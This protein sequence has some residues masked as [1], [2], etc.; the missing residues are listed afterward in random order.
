MISRRAIPTSLL[1]KAYDTKVRL[2]AAEGDF[3]AD[4]WVDEADMSV[5]T[6][7]FGAE[8]NASPSAGDAN[9]DG[10]INATDF[11]IWQRPAQRQPCRCNRRR[12]PAA[13]FLP[14]AS[15]GRFCGA[16]VWGCR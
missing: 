8:T 3:N 13:R 4:G 15:A 7:G 9:S 14:S 6:Q 1:R 5:W 10:A 12:N 11:L 16:D 2:A